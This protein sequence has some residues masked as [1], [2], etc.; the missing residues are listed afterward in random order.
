MVE[1]KLRGLDTYAIMTSST[2][3]RGDENEICVR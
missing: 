2:E 3:V 1:I